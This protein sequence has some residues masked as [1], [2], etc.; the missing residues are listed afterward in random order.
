MKAH[1]P[2]P[3]QA[4]QPAPRHIFRNQ[5]PNGG[6][7]SG[8]DTKENML[9]PT[10]NLQLTLPQGYQ[11]SV[12]EDGSKALMDL[13][14]ELCSHYH[15]NPGLHTLELLSPEGH[16]LGFKPNTLLGSLNVASV[17]IKE[18][19][20]EDKV[21]RRQ[22]PKVPE[23]TV[24]LMVN[25]HSNQK[26]VVRVN[27]LVPLQALIPVICEKCE[28]DPAH[29]L[30]LKDSISRHELPLHKSLTELGIKELYI[31][32]QS[33]V[34]QPKM[35][36][37]PAL[38][39]SDSICSSTTSLGRPEKKGLLGILQFS[40]KKSK[41]ETSVDMDN[42][43]DKVIQNS[44][45]ESNGLSTV[46]GV[47]GVEV[48]PRTLGQSQ[49]VMNIPRMSPKAE[50]KKRRAPAPPGALIC[51]M[52][53][54][55]FEGYQLGL[56]SENQQRK[57]KAPAPPPTPASITP[58]SDNT[59]TS[60]A[61]SP[62]SHSTETPTPAFCTMVA[63][64]IP[65]SSTIIVTET[66]KPVTKKTAA[67]PPTVQTVAQTA[68]SPTPSSSA[69]DSLAL[70]DSNSELSHS[71]D[72][73]DTD[74][75]QAGSHCST[76]TSSTVSEFVEV[77]PTRKS[78]SSRR[79]EDKASSMAALNLKVDEVENNRHSTMAWLHSMH[80][81]RASGQK[82]ETETLE[83]ETLSMG[84]SSG[85]SSL[86]DQGYAASEGMVEGED[87]GMVSSTSDTQPTSPD[88][89]LSLDGSSRSGG[90]RLLG[91]VRDNSSDSDEG[92]ATWVL[93]HRHSDISSQARRLKDSFEDDPEL[94]AQL[95][96]TLAVFE[97]DL[98]D[99]TNF[100]SA[101]ETPYTMSTGSSEVP[102]SVV[103]M[104][105][106]VTAIDEVLEDYEHNA[107]E[108]KEKSLIRTEST[109]KGPDF[110]HQFTTEPRN[111]NN[112]ACTA[113]NES[114]RSNTK[115]PFQLELHMKSP[116][117]IDDKKEEKIIETKMKEMFHIDTNSMKED[118]E[119]SALTK[120]SNVDMQKQSKS[121]ELKP[122]AVKSNA[123][124]VQ[125]KKPV[126]P[127]T[128]QR[129]VSTERGEETHR[130]YQNNTRCNISHGKIMCNVTSR[131]GMKTFT[132][133]PHKPSVMHAAIGEPTVTLTAG[134]IKIDD[135]GNM[136]T[137]G[138]SQNKADGSS[139]S[140][141]NCGQGSSLLG[142]ANTFWS[143]NKKQGSAVLNSK[144]IND[145]AKD[146]T[147][148]LKS[149]PTAASE[150]TLKINNIEYL[151][152]PQSILCTP[153][154]RTQCKEMVKEEAREP[155]K[156]I[157]VV[158]EE[159]EVVEL[160]SKVSVSKKMQPP[161]NKPPLPSPLLPD[162]KRDLSFLKPS[163]QTS[164]QYVAS[165]ISKYTPK[166]SAK[167]NPIPN[168]PN[169]SV[170]TQTTAFQR[171]SRSMP[172]NPR[173]S[174][175]KENGS[176]DSKPNPTSP[177]KSMNYPE[178]ISHSRPVRLNGGGFGSCNGSTKT[179]SDMLETGASKKKHI[180]CSDP[181]QINV[182]ANNDRDNIKHFGPG[183]PTLSQS[184][185]LHSSAK[186]PAAPK[187]I[188]QGQASNK[189]DMTKVATH[190]TPDVKALPSVTV[191]DSTETSEYPQVTVFGPIKKFKPVI[192]G[193][194]EK[195]TSLHSSLMEAIQ[196]GGGRDRLKKISTSSPT[197]IRK[198]SY[199]EEENERSALLSAIRAPRNSDRLRK[200]TS[201]AAVELEK[202]RKVTS[203]EER[204]ADPSPPPSPPTL[205]FTSPPVF[206][207]P[208]P[209]RPQG[210]MVVPPPP[211]PVL[212]QG[213]SSTVAHPNANTPVNPAL[214]REA[215]LEAIR[216][217]S[218]AVR[219]KKVT[220][221]TKTLQ[222]N[223][224]LG[225]IQAAS[226]ALPQK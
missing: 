132:V 218:A 184:R 46:S 169:C 128:S 51:N 38:N 4:P 159:Q 194:V 10:V 123:Q 25:Y 79:V 181:I 75:E 102:V 106:P 41:T 87:S 189:G 60:A 53:I 170:K 214:A 28:F 65:V 187:T 196:T 224:K 3:P 125:E 205:S 24:R 137:L 130:V 16:S 2:P 211:L 19:V 98:A 175:N 192:C 152:T 124:S 155:A 116:E 180:Q 216:S 1:A 113:A 57:R 111:K 201:D 61:P 117:N 27:P 193:S 226:P 66:I 42:Y 131:F 47:H 164:S 63:Q 105:V 219:L 114:N 182:T 143:S 118:K 151:K 40:R 115:Q 88:G 167:P 171:S 139:E 32:D 174:D 200:T 185:P 156:D 178:F 12:T 72:N 206:S 161:S 199:V 71:L 160:E 86:P 195:E 100:V 48:R 215:M 207:P 92:C 222:V 94:T 133:V 8:M 95:H 6:E 138:V 176:A 11:T 67:Q 120:K 31:H 34:V 191:S 73:S 97:A 93:R 43:D 209:P 81:S 202:F 150:T 108:N 136:V 96:D 213:K 197:S 157:Q 5:V 129:P 36:S 39:F 154:E 148:C 90:E 84:S 62:D 104:D 122:D 121:T 77:Q 110:F 69:T 126:F 22:A 26:A 7:T 64:S 49:S 20:W 166:T 221:P 217:G 50:A 18:K 127:Q 186:Q 141:D 80:S 54:T 112:N 82:P 172:M 188:S 99:H 52:D 153:S 208:P 58:G 35:A 83:E 107:V 210:P 212:P 85:G 29:I 78:S 55:S 13:L 91:P 15:L 103:D 183:S 134:A 37:T 223:G 74:F 173:W 149:T 59:S 162:V 44:D 89:S 146:N 76:L 33:I 140:W 70:Q 168:I 45:R 68:S 198:A 190:P 179:G 101:K 135:Q 21:I 177:N 147:G 158:K 56:G 163:R 17:L 204:S 30:L 142:K 165:A 14:V 23:K 145:K 203:E 109:D 225:T 220:V 144:C 9:K 119:R